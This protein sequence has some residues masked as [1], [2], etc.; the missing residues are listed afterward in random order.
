[1]RHLENLKSN[2]QLSNIAR[3]GQKREAATLEK[4]NDVVIPLSTVHSG[5]DDDASEDSGACAEED[6]FVH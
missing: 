1:M 2:L 6:V 3:K 4:R 5:H